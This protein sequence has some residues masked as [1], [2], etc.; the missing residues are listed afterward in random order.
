MTYTLFELKE[1][2]TDHIDEVQILELLNIESVD[3]VERF[4][5]LIENKYEYLCN[6]LGLEDWQEG[7]E[8]D[9]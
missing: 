8:V 5:D 4:E 3:L 1:Y 9:E 6:Q 7:E 2:L